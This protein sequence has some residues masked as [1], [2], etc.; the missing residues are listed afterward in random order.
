MAIAVSQT[1]E[2]PDVA[3]TT[4]YDYAGGATV[5]YIGKAKSSRQPVP[6]T[7]TSYSKANPGVV[8]VT[9]HG[10][11]DDNTVTIFG[12][13]TAGWTALNGT[14]QKVLRTGANTFTIAVD[15]S[16]YAGTFDGKMT[17]TSPQT[18]KA[19]WAIQKYYYSGTNVIRTANASGTTAENQ[20]WDDIATLAFS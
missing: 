20:V 2:F 8:T 4:M 18:S 17:T 12:A 9:A 3:E 16:G 7:V 1:S 14:T 15:T 10:L 19:M 13:T 11:N 5:T 6:L